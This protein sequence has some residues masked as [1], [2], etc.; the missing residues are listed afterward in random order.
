MNLKI[1]A[2]YVITEKVYPTGA[3]TPLVKTPSYWRNLTKK[4]NLWRGTQVCYTMT[5]KIGQLPSWTQKNT[6]SKDNQNSKW[7]RPLWNGRPK[8]WWVTQKSPTTAKVIEISDDAFIPNN[9]YT[10][11]KTVKKYLEQFNMDYIKVPQKLI[12]INKHFIITSW[13]MYVNG[14]PLFVIMS[15]KIRSMMV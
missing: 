2:L 13:V 8:L 7:N 14:L 9:T 4:W 11:G 5:P 1:K 3:T 10:K 15:N 6:T 12:E